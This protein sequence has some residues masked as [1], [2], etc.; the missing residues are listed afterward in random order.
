MQTITV[1][2]TR[3]AADSTQI[4]Q[5]TSYMATSGAG[6]SEQVAEMMLNIMDHSQDVSIQENEIKVRE[7]NGETI[8]YVY[9]VSEDI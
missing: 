2:T 4:S 7:A 6:T 1:T 5:N 9:K 3:Y 8:Y